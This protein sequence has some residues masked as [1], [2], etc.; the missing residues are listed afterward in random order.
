MSWTGCWIS[1]GGGGGIDKVGHDNR[2][3]RDGD[4]RT[5]NADTG[6]S[7]W[8]VTAGVGCDY[9][10]SNRWVIGA[11]AD[12]TWSDI[13]GDHAVRIAGLG[14]IAIG[15]LKNDWSWAV[16]GRLGYLVAP[17]VLTYVNAGFTQTHFA[18]VDIFQ[19]FDDGGAFTGVQLPGQTFNGVFVGSGVEYAF[20]WLP[21]LFLKSE[22]RAAW[23]DRKDSTPACVAFGSRC[24]GPGDQS[25]LSRINVDSHR[26]ITYIGKFELVYRFNWGKQPVVARY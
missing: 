4:L 11:F 26:P 23:F 18:A 17:N 2:D 9:Q 19:R 13:T 12:G 8:L 1:G 7:G 25:W 5:Q 3:P 6:L 20:D 22:G 15:R 16:G 24:D 21:G 14:D 10:F